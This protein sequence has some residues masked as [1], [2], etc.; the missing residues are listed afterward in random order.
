MAEST[1]GS[2]SLGSQIFRETAMRKMSSADDLDHYL[3]VTN[4]SAWVLIGAVA[5]LLVAAFIWGCTA[6]LPLTSNTVGVLKDGEV[7][8]FLPIDNNAM[9]TTESKVTAA[10]FETHITQVNAN[11]H[12]LREVEAA[13][14]SDY[15]AS[16]YSAQ[17]S[18]KVTVA[19]P[20]ELSTW[21]EGDDVPIQ[22][23]TQEV[24][25]LSYLFGKA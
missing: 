23:T 11:P 24:A 5:V 12:S 7:V 25:P 3:K 9:A 6:T 16:N 20:D 2:S 13:I 22:I 8:C 15:V 14:G 21:V 19:L 10:G 1:E 18:Y 17:W 4:P